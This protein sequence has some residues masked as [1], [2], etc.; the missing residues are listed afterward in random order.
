MSFKQIL[1]DI[2]GWKRI[3]NHYTREK[4]EGLPKITLVIP[5]HND[6]H[7]LEETIQSYLIQKNVDKELIIVDANS[8]DHTPAIIEKYKEDI[9]RTYYVTHMNIPMMVNKGFA[10]ARGQYVSFIFPGMQ[11][12][13]QHCLSHIAHLALEDLFP[14][15]I[16]SGTYLA[17]PNFDHIKDA[18]QMSLNEIETE[19]IYFPLNKTWLKRGF[20]PTSP[21]SVWFKRD[22]IKQLG[23]INYKSNTLRGGFYD[24][25][26]RVIRDKNLRITSTFWS[27]TFIDNLSE[28]RYLSQTAVYKTWP[29]IGKY[30]G[31]LS[32]SLWFFRRKPVNFVTFLASRIR[33]FFTEQ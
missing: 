18:L 32:A 1:P 22:Y 19:F 21:C 23:G 7:L 27:T 3:N 10:L 16:F 8:T 2:K 31:W 29:L 12:L 30:F 17:R 20:L 15:I 9:F 11:L 6:G 28:K 25:F 13:N 5:T 24:I 14:E 4:I 33:S 26:C